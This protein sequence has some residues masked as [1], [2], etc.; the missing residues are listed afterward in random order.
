MRKKLFLESLSKDLF[1]VSLMR[2]FLVT[3]VYAALP[4]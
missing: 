4:G 2:F 1:S 3:R